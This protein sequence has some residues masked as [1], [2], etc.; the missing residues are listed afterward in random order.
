M[1][2]C[3]FGYRVCEKVARMRPRHDKNVSGILR[4]TYIR[5]KGTLTHAFNSSHGELVDDVTIVVFS[6]TA[7]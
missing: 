3:F 6:F 2:V 5:S 1:Y 7:T 4:P